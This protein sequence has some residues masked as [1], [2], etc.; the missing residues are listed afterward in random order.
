MKCNSI[1]SQI[2]IL[3]TLDFTITRFYN[4]YKRKTQCNSYGTYFVLCTV[5]IIMSR[6]Y[7][8]YTAYE[9][10]YNNYPDCIIEQL[11]K[12]KK[13]RAWE[14]NPGHHQLK[15]RQYRLD[16]DNTGI[17]MNIII[18]FLDIIIWIT[19]I[20]LGKWSIL[21]IYLIL[22]DCKSEI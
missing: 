16:H 22:T 19:F 21:V 6:H 15:V 12:K 5:Y 2:A 11:K 17:I 20:Q 7:M 13:G 4:Q 1:Y 10:Y 3:N 9:F 18:L 14:S 8:N